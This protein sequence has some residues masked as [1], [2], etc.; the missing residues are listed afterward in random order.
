MWFYLTRP[1]ITKCL[2]LL[3]DYC[4]WACLSPGLDGKLAWADVPGLTLLLRPLL[5]TSTALPSINVSFP[6]LDNKSSHC[7]LD[8][9]SDTRNY[10]S[11][12]CSLN[13]LFLNHFLLVSCHMFPLNSVFHLFLYSQNCIK[14][15]QFKNKP[16]KST[17]FSVHLRQ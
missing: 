12:H 16:S 2:V 1:L 7:I 10:T 11:S 8:T 6:L 14:E 15:W 13:E 9:K 4:L 5:I 17:T 3:L